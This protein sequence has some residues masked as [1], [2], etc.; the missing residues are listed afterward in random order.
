MKKIISFLLVISM[1]T[2]V[3]AGCGS[4]SGNQD[5]GSSEHSVKTFPR[6]L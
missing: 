1:M 6:E 4:T 5:S 3:L 2:L